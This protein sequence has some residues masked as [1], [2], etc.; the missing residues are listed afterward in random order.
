MGDTFD[1]VS[2]TLENNTLR[3]LCGLMVEN[4][5]LTWRKSGQKY[6]F[7]I[8]EERAEH[9]EDTWEGKMKH[10]RKL[11]TRTVE[12]QKYTLEES[13]ENFKTKSSKRLEEKHDRFEK[14][15]EKKV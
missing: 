9:T 10:L 15:V 11:M 1:R 13:I 2:E 7:I 5:M 3:E 4:D 8:N 6:I 12:T 14:Q